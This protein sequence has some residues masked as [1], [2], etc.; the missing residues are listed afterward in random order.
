MLV[1]NRAKHFRHHRLV[2]P[3]IA[4]KS[5]CGDRLSY[6]THR[7]TVGRCGSFS[8]DCPMK[9]NTQQIL[10]LIGIGIAIVAGTSLAISTDLE[11]TPEPE[12]KNI[13]VLVACEKLEI[14]KPFPTP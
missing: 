6:Q 4:G 11:R 9:P 5:A 13:V 12:V 7:D 10:L 1:R 8:E 14:G 2:W 3:R